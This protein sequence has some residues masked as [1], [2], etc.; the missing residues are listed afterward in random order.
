VLTSFNFDLVGIINFHELKRRKNKKKKVRFTLLYL[1]LIDIQ[2]IM[3]IE[4]ILDFLPP[5]ECGDVRWG[6][7][8]TIDLKI[9]TYCFERCH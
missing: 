7:Q 9:R 5:I 8:G 4:M 1:L 2:I 3:L 6:Q